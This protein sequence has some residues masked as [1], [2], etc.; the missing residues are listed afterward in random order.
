MEEEARRELARVAADGLDPLPRV[1]LARLAHLPD[2]RL[3]GA[4]RRG[5]GGARLPGA[6]AARRGERDDRPSGR[7]LRGRRP[8]PGHARGDARR[9]GARRAS[10]S[11]GAIELN[12][13]MGADDLARPHAPTSTPACC[14]S[15]RA[16]T[17]PEPR[18]CSARR[19]ARR[20]DRDGD[21]ARPD[22]G[23]RRRARR[24]PA[25]PTGSPRAR[26]RSCGSSPAGSATARSARTLFDQRAHGRQ[27][28]P[29]HPA[30]DR[31]REPHRGRLLRAPPRSDRGLRPALGSARC[32]S[33]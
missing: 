14:S 19:R 29:Q 3:R 30:Q 6:R 15:A 5:D 11:S 13:R 2:R 32:R 1:A 23:A 17:A 20:A 24:R 21:A 27:P 31:L 10:T 22:P 25:C 4:R 28:R 16:A 8:L 33:T 12:R 7:L 26:R 9:V 18:R